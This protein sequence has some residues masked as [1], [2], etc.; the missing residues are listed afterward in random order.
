MCSSFDNV[1]S[2]Y[3]VDIGRPVSFSDA[4]VLHLCDFPQTHMVKL[5]Q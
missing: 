5:L 3:F 1:A 2:M 4:I